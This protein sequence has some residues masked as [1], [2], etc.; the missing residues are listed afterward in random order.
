MNSERLAEML[1]ELSNL[2]RSKQALRQALEPSSTQMSTEVSQRIE[3][4]P[5]DFLGSTCC[6][7]RLRELAASETVVS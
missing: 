1:G 6:P 5:F 2:S 7:R 3:Q 4:E